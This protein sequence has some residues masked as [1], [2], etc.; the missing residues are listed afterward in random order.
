MSKNELYETAEDA[1][2]SLNIGNKY[3]KRHA[4]RRLR[5]FETAVKG[6]H[7]KYA[8]ARNYCGILEGCIYG[9]EDGIDSYP[10]N[11]SVKIGQVNNTQIIVVFSDTYELQEEKMQKLVDKCHTNGVTIMPFVKEYPRIYQHGGTGSYTINDKKVKMECSGYSNLYR[12]RLY[13]FYIYP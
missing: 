7:T 4:T 3:D 5:A 8:I 9:N 12:G 13:G 6:K 11:K 10:F 1:F 2:K